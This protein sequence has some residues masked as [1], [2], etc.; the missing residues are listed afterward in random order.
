MVPYW[1]DRKITQQ[2]QNIYVIHLTAVARHSPH[3]SAVPLA[4]L[5]NAAVGL[6]WCFRDIHVSFSDVYIARYTVRTSV[7]PHAMLAESL[8]NGCV[9]VTCPLAH[10]IA[11]VVL[12]PLPR[13]CAF[14]LSNACHLVSE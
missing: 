2:S 8:V 10:S 11:Q 4:K 9:R 7:C 6:V 3:N 1:R 13:A 14:I 12:E 5:F